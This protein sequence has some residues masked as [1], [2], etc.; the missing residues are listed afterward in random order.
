LPW[1]ISIV[2]N[3]V[4]LGENGN[5][6]YAFRSKSFQQS[7]REQRL[8]SWKNGSGQGGDF[9]FGHVAIVAIECYTV[10]NSDQSV[11]VY[12]RSSS[13][14]ARNRQRPVLPFALCFELCELCVPGTVTGRGSVIKSDLFTR[15][16]RF[17]LRV[18]GHSSLAAFSRF[19]P[20]AAEKP[21]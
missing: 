7:S 17:S 6:P 14:V 13:G 12:G 15:T 2:E 21:R 9:V 5:C 10:F 8:S 4:T 1:M 3:C 19:E 20:V 18:S 11:F 16:R